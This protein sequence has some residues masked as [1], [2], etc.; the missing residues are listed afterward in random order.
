M[1]GISQ[2]QG[3]K[4]LDL[5]NNSII[6]IEGEISLIVIKNNNN[7]EN[8]FTPPKVVNTIGH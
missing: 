4:V 7:L 3:L 5:S 8:K 6:T 2:A 1:T